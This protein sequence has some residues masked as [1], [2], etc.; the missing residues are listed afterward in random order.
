MGCDPSKPKDHHHG[1]RINVKVEGSPDDWDNS[2]PLKILI[3][4]CAA[5]YVLLNAKGDANVG[6][7]S[8]LIRLT[9][10]KFPNVPVLGP[11]DSV[12]V[13]SFFHSLLREKK[14]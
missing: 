14:S 9:E 8:L 11:N 3:L 5:F 10:K 12:R 4:V 7:T 2:R 13:H 6:K 1:G